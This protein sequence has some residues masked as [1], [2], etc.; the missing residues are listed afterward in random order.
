MK[1]SVCIKFSNLS[2]KFNFPSKVNLPDFFS[3]LLCEDTDTPDAEYQ[4]ELLRSPLCP[5]G[6]A[7]LER[8]DFSVYRTKDGWLRIY[9]P[10]TAEDGCCVAC[11]I[12]ESGKHTL[13]YPATM[14]EH[15]RSYFHC[16]HLMCGE[17]MLLM[18]NALLLHSSVV[19]IE[20]KTLLF[21]GASGAGK[22]TQANLWKQYR[23]AEILNG[24]RA[25]IMKKGTK[26]FA[27]GSIWCGTSRIYRAEQR[28][29]AGIF[30]LKKHTENII[31]PLSA[32]AFPILFSQTTVNDWDKD[33]V[34][35]ICT[36]YTDLL[37]AVPVYE[38]S[39][40]ADK[41]AVDLTYK[42]IFAKED[43]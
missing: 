5:E 7:V 28:E 40:R 29:I 26:F 21:C 30:V 13:Y 6:Y 1:S 33:F 27:G 31:R 43:I 2:L 42:T 22:S 20:D 12:R 23:N 4:I 25:L 24:D 37:S 34:D 3:D 16:A 14:W 15:Y 8:K 9:T 11:L 32:E 10:L 35:K 17:L 38:L 36:I 39:C 41:E 19:M 18:Q